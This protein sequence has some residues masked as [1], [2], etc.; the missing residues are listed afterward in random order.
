MSR[1][2]KVY[3]YY[4]SLQSNSPMGQR[5]P[6]YCQHLPD[7]KGIASIWKFFT[8]QTRELSIALHWRTQEIRRII[9]TKN[10]CEY[11][12]CMQNVVNKE[13]KWKALKCKPSALKSCA[14]KNPA[15]RLNESIWRICQAS[16][17]RLEKLALLVFQV[18]L[19]GFWTTL[20]TMLSKEWA[21]TA[22]IGLVS[23]WHDFWMKCLLQNP[24]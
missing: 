24:N 19:L 6:D 8:V 17:R 9:S 22:T 7:I 2:W 5:D 4:S 13:T 23:K 15:S 16:H 12:F 11:L 1:L 20:Y 18:A 10:C 3:P 14:Y 21:L